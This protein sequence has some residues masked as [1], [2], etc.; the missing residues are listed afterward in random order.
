[1]QILKRLKEVGF[2]ISIDDFGTGHSSLSYLKQFPI[3]ELKIDKSFV[4]DLPDD[5]DD[6]AI[7]RAIIALS[8]NMGYVNVAEGI[9]TKEQEQFLENNGCEIG[10]GYYFCKPQIKDDLIK[11]FKKL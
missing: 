6:V 10:Q 2:E 7:A 8:Q 9:E 4:D 11:F 5:Q 3:S 1:M